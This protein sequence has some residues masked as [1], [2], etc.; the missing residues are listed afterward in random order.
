[1]RPLVSLLVVVLALSSSPPTTAA[2]V[3]AAPIRY[4]A[5]PD[6]ALDFSH[7]LTCPGAAQ[8]MN[9]ARGEGL[10]EVHVYAALGNHAQRVFDPKDADAFYLPV[11]EFLSLRMGRCNGA[12]H[13]Q[14]M[15]S[16]LGSLQQSTYF[17][18]RGGRDHFWVRGRGTS[19]RTTASAPLTPAPPLPSPSHPAGVVQ[20]AHLRARHGGHTARAPEQKRDWHAPAHAAALQGAARDDRR[21]HEGVW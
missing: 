9:S 12:D 21:A 4:Y 19:S 3:L 5:Y 8:L 13:A 7:L 16:A 1:M 14:R 17:R 11:M 2:D 15:A 10:Q 20:I 6:K 18:R